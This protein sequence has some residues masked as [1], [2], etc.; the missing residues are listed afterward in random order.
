MTITASLP[1]ARVGEGYRWMQL[2]IGV[3][4]MVMIANLQYG[5]TFFVP[6]IQKTFGWDRAAIQWAF[7]LFVLFETWLVPIEGWFVDKYGPRVVV[8]FGG[9][10]CAIGWVMNAYA[11]TLGAFYLAQ[12]IAGIGAGAVYGTC[13]GNALKWFPEKRGLA[14]GITAAGFGAG[15]ALTVAPIQS[16]IATSGFQAAFF[17]FGIGQGVIICVLSLILLAPKPGQVPEMVA[18][19]NII[20]TRR[21]YSPVEVVRQPIFWLMYF[22][23]VIVGAGGLMVTANLK[24][25]AADIKVDS[26][27]VTL[28]GVTMTA[29]TFAATIDRVLN[30]LTRPFFG[31]VSDNIGRENTM[32]IAF[33]MEGVGIYMLYLWGHDP[34]WFVLLSGFVFFAWGEIYSLFP[35]TCT[36]TF[37]ARFAATNAG[38]LYTAKGTAALLVPLANYVQQGTGN[39]NLVFLIA[40]GANIL[41]SVLAIAVLKPWRRKVVAAA[42]ANT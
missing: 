35:S 41:A 34:L 6:D 24:P 10:L 21:N 25:I 36:D 5:W 2:T 12:I 37:G 19:A 8:M 11:T 30:G 13:V 29:I 38:L 1:A 27:P 16:M 39:W 3:I 7:T 15:S 32:F 9:V 18:N 31:W 26:I 20:Q 40:A 14:A 4:C 22:M 28:M 23:F 17:N 33:A 42:S